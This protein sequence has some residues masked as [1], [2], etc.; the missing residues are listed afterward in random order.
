M[1]DLKHKK[2]EQLLCQQMPFLAFAV[3]NQLETVSVHMIHLV[4][5][6]FLNSKVSWTLFSLR[7]I[8]VK[9]EIQKSD[10]EIIIVWRVVFFL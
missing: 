6:Q 9:A 5:Q 2:M 4:E 3:K 10:K 7:T 8:T 1:T